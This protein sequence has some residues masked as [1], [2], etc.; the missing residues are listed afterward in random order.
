MCL[1]TFLTQKEMVYLKNVLPPTVSECEMLAAGHFLPVSDQEN[2]TRTS[3]ED[4]EGSTKLIFIQ[5]KEMF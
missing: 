4:E 5:K 3:S 2:G 1:D